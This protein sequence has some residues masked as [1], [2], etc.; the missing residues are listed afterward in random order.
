MLSFLVNGYQCNLALVADDLIKLLRI[1]MLE[2]LFTF[3]LS[4]LIALVGDT[5]D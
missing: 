1:Y 2:L 5:F 4:G 3:R